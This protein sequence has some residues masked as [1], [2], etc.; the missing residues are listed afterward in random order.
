MLSRKKGWPKARQAVGAGR[1][2]GAQGR[3]GKGRTKD[4]HTHTRLCVLSAL[5]ECGGRE[6]TGREIP[7]FQKE[8]RRLG[9]WQADCQPMTSGMENGKRGTYRR[10]RES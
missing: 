9:E 6:K 7:G 3:S 10:L 1:E 5:S 4:T 8:A 2:I